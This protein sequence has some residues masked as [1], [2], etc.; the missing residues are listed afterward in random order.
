VFFVAK[1]NHEDFV[2]LKDLM[3]A[4]RIVPVIDRR[5]SLGE[6]AQ[7]MRYLVEGGALGKIV[8]TMTMKMTDRIGPRRLLP[9]RE[10]SR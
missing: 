6:T 4:G 9:F 10:V 5:Y 1:T 2:V 3:E 7:A 8:I